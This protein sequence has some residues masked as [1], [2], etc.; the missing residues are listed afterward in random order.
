MNLCVGVIWVVIIV[1]MVLRFLYCF[2]L[3]KNPD[4]F[5]KLKV[6]LD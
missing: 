5:I 1:I 4:T 2:K 6:K 3:G